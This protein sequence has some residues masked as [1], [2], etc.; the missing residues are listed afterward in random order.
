MTGVGQTLDDT[1][2]QQVLD[3][4]LD[5]LMLTG[6]GGFTLERAAARSGVDVQEIRQVW[7]NAPALVTAALRMFGDRHLPIPDTGTLAGDLLQFARSYAETVNSSTGRRMLDAV[8]I[9]RTDWDLTESRATF[10][11]GR[12]S[13]IGVIVRRGIERG[14]CPPETD[15]TLT[16][17]MLA[18]GLCLPVL[19]YDRPIT[20]EHCQYVVATLL[21]GITGNR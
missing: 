15:P 8:L 6:V 9:K 13:R 17:D 19:Y 2:R 16:I 20:D 11:E 5:E 21:H 3:A 4:A 18:I 12:Q 7:A 1:T 10:L 14:Q